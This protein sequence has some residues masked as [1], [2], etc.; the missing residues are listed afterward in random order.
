MNGYLY[1]LG[2]DNITWTCALEDEHDDIINEANANPMIGHFQVDTKTKKILQVDIW[3]SILHKDCLE[4]VKKCDKCQRRGW[5]LWKK[6]S[7]T[8]GKS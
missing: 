8:F 1:K 3:W 5:R 2:I 6:N 4:H 7:L